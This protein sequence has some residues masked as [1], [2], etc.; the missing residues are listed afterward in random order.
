MPRPARR[1][2]PFRPLTAV[3][4]LLL[5]G[6]VGAGAPA[7]AES[8]LRR[9]ELSARLYET[10]QET[11]D[12]LL[13]LA[14]AR[15]RKSV[16]AM[17]VE[18]EPRREGAAAEGV[19]AAPQLLTWQEMLDTARTLARGDAA[20]L[21]LADGFSEGEVQARGV[22]SGQV[23]SITTIGAEARDIYPKLDFAGGE[24]AEVYVEATEPD[25]DLKLRITDAQG[26]LVCEDADMGPI[27]YCGW[28]PPQ[29]GFFVL[30]VDN[31]SRVSSSYA[32]ITN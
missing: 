3:G 31:D 32:L 23:Y 27:A 10:A 29:T 16:T 26:N 28:R 6:L 5:A 24:Y 4:L 20:I 18:R 8:T 17:Q 21:A 1:T 22:P 11:R 2:R 13:A 19:V 9:A 25:A 14:A 7:R 15:L 12:P 30:E